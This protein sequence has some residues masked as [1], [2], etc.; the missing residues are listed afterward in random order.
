MHPFLA[1]IYDIERRVITEQFKYFPHKYY[2]DNYFTKIW[3]REY[4]CVGQILTFNSL[5]YN[6]NASNQKKKE[7]KNNKNFAKVKVSSMFT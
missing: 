1:P 5:L 4:V 3:E 2:N 6:I 7:E